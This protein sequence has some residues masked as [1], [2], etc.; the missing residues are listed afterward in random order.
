MLKRFGH[1][2]PTVLNT[3]SVKL[4]PTKKQ[5]SN[6]TWD[7]LFDSDTI[8]L[9][10]PDGVDADECLLIGEN[11]VASSGDV[12]KVGSWVFYRLPFARRPT[13]FSK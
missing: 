2:D 5:P 11:V 9:L 12:C 6:C 3:G 8:P 13:V 4:V 7:E 10:R 1:S